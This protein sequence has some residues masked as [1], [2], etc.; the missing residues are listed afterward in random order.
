L[1]SG[2]LLANEA[3]IAW[4]TAFG[5][6]EL[7]DLF[8]AQARFH[9]ALHERDRLKEIGRLT[10]QE[11]ERLSTL[12]EHWGAEAKRL[13]DLPLPGR[14]AAPVGTPPEARR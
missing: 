10:P 4:H 6:R 1:E 13:Y 5:F 11:D 7:P 8:V 3:S 9:A 12:A 14:L 2:A